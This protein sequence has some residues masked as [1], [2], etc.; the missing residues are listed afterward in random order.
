MSLGLSLLPRFCLM[1]WIRR[2]LHREMATILQTLV[3]CTRKFYCS[4]TQGTRKASFPIHCCSLLPLPFIFFILFILAH[5]SLLLF[6]CLIWRA[7][8]TQFVW[9][10]TG[11]TAGVRFLVGKRDFSLQHSVQ[12]GSW[13]HTTSYLMGTVGSFPG[14]NAAGTWRWPLPNSYVFYLRLFLFVVW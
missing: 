8:I 3:P 12:I 5:I 10:A 1:I 7:G 4:E 9:L 6:F 11:W 2:Q 14:S 13:A